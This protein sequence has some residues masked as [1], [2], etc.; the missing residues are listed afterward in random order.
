MK[1]TENINE[2][3]K[4][5][6]SLFASIEKPTSVSPNAAYFGQLQKNVWGEINQAT[7]IAQQEN[8]LDSLRQKLEWI[9]MPKYALSMAV[10]FS[11]LLLA[12]N[13]FSFQNTKDKV[14][15]ASLSNTEIQSFLADNIDE[16]DEQILMQEKIEF[17]FLDEK[18][19]SEQIN[20]YLENDYSTELL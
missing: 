5:I 6:S 11:F 20:K 16:F 14:M 17:P 18:V 4:A 12:I 19:S 8:W 1:N 7:P 10:A 15:L 3:L 13:Y 9:F 2:E